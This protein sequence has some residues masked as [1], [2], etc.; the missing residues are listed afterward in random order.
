[1]EWV[2]DLPDTQHRRDWAK[3]AQALRGK[4]GEWAKISE[5]SDRS[6]VTHISTARLTSFSPAGAYEATS[7]GEGNRATIYARYVGEGGEYADA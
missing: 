7:R 1:M 4:P 3:V 5:D 6:L 2:D